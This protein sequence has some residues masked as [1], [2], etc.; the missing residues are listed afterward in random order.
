VRF[1]SPRT[2]SSEAKKLDG[3]TIAHVRRWVARLGAAAERPTAI[4][5]RA[6]W[7]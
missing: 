6:C 3:L 1:G 5:P 4:R 2:T 7:W